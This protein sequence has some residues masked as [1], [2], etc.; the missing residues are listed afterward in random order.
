MNITQLTA[1][2]GK[3]K[4]KEESNPLKTLVKPLKVKVKD[5]DELYAAKMIF[6]I[7]SDYIYFEIL[8][9]IF[10]DDLREKYNYF[11]NNSASSLQF[12]LTRDIN[13]FHYLLT[14]VFNDLNLEL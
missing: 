9:E 3:R 6:D 7:D 5:D 2:L 4:L 14:S 12:Y 10:N 13:S 8:D 1:I 11:G